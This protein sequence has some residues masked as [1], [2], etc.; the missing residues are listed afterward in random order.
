M[1]SVLDATKL[2]SERLSP[3]RFT[4]SQNVAKMAV[5]LA[6]DY[7]A[8][9]IKAELAGLLHDYAKEMSKASLVRTAS[10][11]NLDPSQRLQLHP[12]LLHGPVAAH[13]LRTKGFIR[14]VEILDAIAQH[15]VGQANMTAL[16]KIIYVADYIEPS[17][18]FRDEEWH[19]IQT[20]R[21]IGLNALTLYVA[22]QTLQYLLKK[23]VYIHPNALALYNTLIEQ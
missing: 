17:R 15:T 13:L 14:D 9:M 1:L 18:S 20:A 2:I 10:E 5:Q 19:A 23:Q 12:Q 4:H 7:G 16:G 22:T 3:Q 21:S 8:D 11:G 6:S